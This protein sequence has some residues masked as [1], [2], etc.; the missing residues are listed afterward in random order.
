MIKY[1]LTGYTE[2]EWNRAV[3]WGHVPTEQQL[4]MVDNV[5]R[6]RRS[7]RETHKKIKA[8][9]TSHHHRLRFYF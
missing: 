3:G 1:T 4:M 7:I 2:N 5:E 8:Q 6:F 9:Q